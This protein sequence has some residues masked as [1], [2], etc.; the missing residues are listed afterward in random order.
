[1]LEYRH[2]RFTHGPPGGRGYLYLKE[3][4]VVD[5]ASQPWDTAQ[6]RQAFPILKDV[7]YLNT[8]TYGLMPEP[9][10]AAFLE[11]TADFERGG[12]AARGEFYARMGVTR[13]RIAGLLGATSQEIAFTRN[14]TDGVN[15]VL[16][17]LEWQPGD[18]VITTDEEHPAIAHPLGY[19]RRERGLRIHTVKVSPRADVMLARLEAVVTPATR[20]VIMSHV[21]C[22]TGT[23]L[24]AREICAWAA[25]R[26]LLTL[27]DG[28]QVLGAAP[29]NVR[30]LGCDFYASNGHKWLGGPKGT[31]VFYCRADRLDRLFMAHVG[32]GSLER[33]DLATGVAE[34]FHSGLRFEFGTRAFALP[35]GLG[36]SLDWLEGLGWDNVYGRITGLARYLK[37]RI[38][39]RPYLS[40][41]TPYD[42][43]DSSGLTSFAIAGRS[44]EETCRR[45]REQWRIY[46]RAVTHNNLLRIATAHFNSED[47]IDRLLAALDQSLWPVS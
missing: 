31:G 5:N 38:L 7:N 29:V 9:A 26:G 22:E 32:A 16:A 8:G 2:L 36:G 20:L 42:A 19:L 45:L 15:L 28:A 41:L 4:H 39:E 44:A 27:F 24:P 25:G 6:V 37:D 11:M 33:A 3:K 35:A 1:M 18:E 14:A 30:E 43:A 47:D 46:T 17:G 23:R 13:Q 12:Q 21:T 40:L 34:P 10:L